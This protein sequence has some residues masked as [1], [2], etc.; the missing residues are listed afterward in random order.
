MRKTQWVISKAIA[1]H[2]LKHDVFFHL[3]EKIFIAFWRYILNA[4]TYKICLDHNYG[5]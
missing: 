1:K 2:G 3:I 5:S 4:K